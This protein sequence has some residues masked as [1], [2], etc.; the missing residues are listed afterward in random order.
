MAELTSRLAQYAA[1]SA[2]LPAAAASGAIQWSGPGPIGTA[3]IG[4][5]L[6]VDFGAG[7][8]EV[9]RFEM[10]TNKNSGTF[11]ASTFTS[12]SYSYFRPGGSYALHLCN[13]LFQFNPANSGGV[14]LPGFLGTGNDPFRLGSGAAIS[15]GLVFVGPMTSA[16]SASHDIAHSVSTAVQYSTGYAFTTNSAVGGWAGGDRGFIG[17]VMQLGGADRFGWFDVEYLPGTKELIIHG[18]AYNDDP[19]G[20]IDAGETP[21]PGVTGLLALAMGAA[22]IRRKRAAVA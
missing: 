4:S 12:N 19:D 15:S 7:V 3:T 5:P 10:V 22:G 11:P 9:F 2:V 13:P 1:L 16:F 20:P 17:F 14:V 8:G 21:T 18:W 6:L